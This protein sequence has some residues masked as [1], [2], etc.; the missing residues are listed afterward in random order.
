MKRRESARTNLKTNSIVVSCV[1]ASTPILETN[2]TE[3]PEVVELRA[4]SADLRADVQAADRILPFYEQAASLVE[5]AIGMTLG[6]RLFPVQRAGGRIIAAGGIAE[7]Q[8][9]EGKTL[10][11]TV[12]LYLHA[13]TGKGAHLAT[14]NDYLARRDAEWMGPVYRALGLSVGVIVHGL[15]DSQ[16]REAY[17]CD[18]TY[19]TCR[20]FGFDFLRD[21]LR[22]RQVRENQQLY[23]DRGP[24][25]LDQIAVQRLPNFI[26]VDEAD[27]LLIDDARTPLVISAA[28]SQAQR[29]EVELY[30]WCARIVGDF[31]DDLDYRYDREKRKVELTHAGMARL[32]QTDKPAALEGLG[33]VDFYDFMERAIKVERDFH[34]DQHYVVR[35]GKIVIVDESTGRIAEGRRWS[36]GIHQSIEAKEKLEIEVQ[37]SNAA[38]ITVQQLVNRYPVVAGMTGTAIECR[39]EFHRVYKSRTNRIE[40]NRPLQ[41][42]P[43]PTR[44]FHTRDE[45]WAAV[46][47]EIREVSSSG[48]PVLVGT[49]TIENSELLSRLLTEARIGHVVLNARQIEHEAAIVAQA[50]QPGRVT[51]A[52]NMAGRGTDIK[53]GE[54]IVE[55]GGL[56]V[57]CAELHDSARIDRQLFGRCGRQGDPGTTRLYVSA[58]DPLLELAYGRRRAARMRN[59]YRLRSPQWWIRTFRRAQQRIE[60]EH[61]RQRQIMMHS[62]KESF[63]VLRE[64]GRDPY[65]DTVE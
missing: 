23:G 14:A 8:T 49:R 30:Q 6:F 54:G 21:R 35:D 62:Q 29:R 38:Q 42:N 43:L 39:R 51:V 3:L 5:R 18:V 44:F 34:L 36:R 61:F 55:L 19:G 63:K 47:D 22:R 48:R 50:G 25:S 1:S 56:H 45:K 16:R 15:T 9:G 32:R 52:T 13:L 53:L 11:A 2:P 4:A 57:I 24:A 33:L 46:V 37:T 60:N 64:S 27:S 40:T 26:L 59:L 65:L 28:P 12:P 31:E 17:F 58:E 10:T 20:E 41:R 7:M